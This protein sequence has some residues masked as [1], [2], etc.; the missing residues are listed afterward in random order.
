MTI[1]R[2]RLMQNFSRH[3]MQYDARAD[4]Q[5]RQTL[6]V[7]DAAM[8]LLPEQARILDIG[9]GTGQFAAITQ[10]QR[11]HWHIYG[12]DI[13]AGMCAA[14]SKHCS[15]IQTDAEVLPFAD[16]SY[17]GV[18]SSLCLQWVQQ[19]ARAFTEITR[20]LKPGGRA[21]ITT[22]LNGTLAEL[23]A[24]SAEAA[25]S[26]SLLP[27]RTEAEYRST[28]EEAGLRVT[29]AEATREVRHYASVCDLMNSM[30]DIGAGN[31]FVREP[32]GL[33]GA[34]RWKA[35]LGHYETLRAPEGIPATWH[36]LFLVMSKP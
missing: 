11:T 31:N 34:Q 22:L 1:A 25:L 14:A 16:A 33:M 18:V 4:L 27:M 6:R 15:A 30:R 32:Q 26:L 28:A 12:A 24:A 17:D 13:A 23:Q 9:C 5:H 29:M 8:M 36:T 19:P 21:I 7:A 20:V 2:A 10:T 35:M 3:A